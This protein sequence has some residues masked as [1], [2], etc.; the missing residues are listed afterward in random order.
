MLQSSD[1]LDTNQMESNTN[2]RDSLVV[3][4]WLNEMSAHTSKVQRGDRNHSNSRPERLI[5]QSDIQSFILGTGDDIF[6]RLQPALE[7]AQREIIFVT[8]FWARSE[9]LEILKSALETLSTLR[10]GRSKVRIRIGF[11]SLS[12]SQKLLQTSSLD[13]KTYDPKEWPTKLGLPAANDLR[14]LD[15]Q[16]KSIF[17]RPFSVMHPKFIIIDRK[18]VWLPSCNVSWESWFEGCV[19]LTGPVVQNFVTFWQRFWGRN[20]SILE[21]ESNSSIT[22]EDASTSQD[23]EIQKPGPA[24]IFRKLELRSVPSV[25]LLSPHHINPRFMLLPW[26]TPAPPST[27]LNMFLLTL[28]D[29]A[30][31]N[32]YIQTPNITSPPVLKALLSALQRGVHVNIV[33][34]ERLM[35]LEQLFTAGTTTARCVKKLVRK[36]RRMK[37]KSRNNDEEAGL[38]RI[39]NLVV[40]YFQPKPPIT[41]GEPLQSHLKLTIVDEEW[42][43]LGSGN[44]DRASWYTSQELDV[45]FR[46]RKF[47]R[48]VKDNV[49]LVLKERKRVAFS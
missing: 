3:Q 45:A 24:H 46:D 7:S 8:C 29:L 44:M 1:F 43:V 41:L 20:E 26:T 22:G 2:L 38:R 28:F 10:V 19:V 23:H 18:E 27:P 5:S 40:E 15:V 42:V 36:H 47:A 13:G 30:T 39:G 11:S 48:T 49:D 16:V 4:R 32:I 14:G 33:T 35:I 34:S 37:K 17:V 6:H 12:L 31:H 21:M 9:S 25:F